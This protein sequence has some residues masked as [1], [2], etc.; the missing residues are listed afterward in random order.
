MEL[1]IFT[2]S[3]GDVFCPSDLKATPK[4]EMYNFIFR[5][6][7]AFPRELISDFGVVGAFFIGL[8]ISD[9]GEYSIYSQYVWVL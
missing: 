6:R 4:C 9:F 7:K 5:N 2:R 3:N 8:C 1:R